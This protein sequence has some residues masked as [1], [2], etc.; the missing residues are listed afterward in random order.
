MCPQK[1][2]HYRQ[3]IMTSLKQKT[4]IKPE[5][6]GI[7]NIYPSEIGGGEEGECVQAG[8]KLFINVGHVQ[9]D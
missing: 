7:K 5:Y 1:N 3:E 8:H 6:Y 2:V 9:D 4:R